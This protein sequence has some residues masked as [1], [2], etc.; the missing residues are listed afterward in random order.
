MSKWDRIGT[1]ALTVIV[2]L[3]CIVGTWLVS[4]SWYEIDSYT[5]DPM[6]GP[7]P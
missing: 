4:Q 6:F 5:F 3:G 1:T 2:I 7:A